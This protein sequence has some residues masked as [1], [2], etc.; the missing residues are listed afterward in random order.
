MMKLKIT[1]LFI[2]LFT[3]C[4][5]TA[6]TVSIN[7]APYG[8]IT[9]AIDAASNGDVILISGIH[10]GT[11]TFG[12]SITL[13]G[14]DP[15][16][17]IIQEAETA[18]SDG[19][20]TGVINVIR[21]EDADVLTVTIENLG[22]RNGN[23]ANNGGGIQADK[24]TG[25]L[26]LK[27]L[28]IEN[29]HT[30]KNGGGLGIVGTNAEIENCTI[31]NNSSSLDGG[32]LIVTPNNGSGVDNIVHIKQSLMNNNNGRNAG[33]IYINGNNGFGNDYKIDVTIEN[34]TISNNT[35]F[36]PS[37]GNGGGAIFCTSFPL[38]SNTSLGNTTL[39]FMHATVYNNSHA[40]LIKSG[41]Q[42]AGNAATP[43]NFSAY[44]SI[45]VAN[46][47]LNMKALNFANTN[48][49]N[50]INCVLG[51]L[52]AAP[53]LIDD[54]DKN[55]LKGRTATQAGLTGTVAD[56]GGKTHVIAITESSSADDF[57]TAT[58][59]FALPTVDQRGATREGA[60]DAGAFEFGGVL[61]TTKNDLL[62]GLNIYPNPASTIV[63]INGVENIESIK[64]FSILGS[65]EMKAVN[66]DYLDVSNL[67]TG[68]YFIQVTKGN[69]ATTKKLIIK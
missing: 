37:S 60:P 53:T 55:N 62:S 7:G 40:N 57:C 56:E 63:R 58:I 47:D 38:T 51:G 35:T 36:S 34:S 16:T 13:R 69:F 61:S 45:I 9:E 10:T 11:I 41:I 26:T 49:T 30:T 67:S 33:G 27:N 22:I 1:L 28:I 59:P 20:G 32:G 21:A 25:L 46:D 54:T 68:I 64:V 17:D 44:N 50:V 4:S 29:N 66:T 6:Q 19:S 18:A 2:T 43:T 52:N 23:S 8:T 5:I 15:T 39:S 14:T 65:L 31:Q 24:I 48:T 42:F 3:I 12:K